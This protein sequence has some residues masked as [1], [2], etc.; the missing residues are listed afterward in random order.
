MRLVEKDR[1]VL[2]SIEFVHEGTEMFINV[3]A[4]PDNPDGDGDHVGTA[5]HVWDEVWDSFRE[6]VTAD[7]VTSILRP[8]Q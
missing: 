7:I 5:E 1:I 6:A 8:G 3:L 2:G 4:D